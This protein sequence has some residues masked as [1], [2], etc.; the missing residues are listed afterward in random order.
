MPPRHRLLAAILGALTA[1]GPLGVDMYLPAFPMMA[2]ELGVGPGAIQRTLATFLLGMAVGQLVHGPLSDRLGRRAPLFAGLAIYGLA[3]VGCAVAQDATVLAWLRLVQA[4]GGCVGIVVARAMVRDLC[5]E[6]GAVRMSAALMLAMGAAPI[7]APALGG[8]LMAGL[9]WRSIFWLLAVYAAAMMVIVALVLP[10]SLPPER[11]RRDNLLGIVVVYGRILGDR[12]FLSFALAGA[13]PMSG[14]F[15]YLTA[16][17]GVLME[18]HGLDPVTYGMAFG[19]NA[20]GLIVT[21]QIVSRLVRRLAPAQLLVQA[22]AIQAAMGLLAAVAAA[23]GLLWPLLSALFLYLSVM[24]ALLPLAGALAMATQGP[25]AGSASAVIGALQFGTGALVG[26]GFG[27]L[28]APAPIA[29]GGFLAVAG[30]AGL[31]AHHALRR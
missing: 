28:S 16:S 22:L 2:A 24:G 7:L 26:T 6:R 5:D 4:L 3:S 12:R 25:V 27:L 1:L 19:A 13:L 9:G 11:R 14:L 31:A 10:E 30:L 20:V 8:W 17:P 21:S 15:A 29:M 23:S 18:I